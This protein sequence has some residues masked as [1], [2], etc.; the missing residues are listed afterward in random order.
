VFLQVGRR[1]VLVAN[2]Q[3]LVLARQQ[4]QKLKKR[5]KGN[6]SS[7]ECQKGESLL[8]MG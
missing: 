5:K 8:L 2:A 3:L 1:G 4:R 7:R 6:A